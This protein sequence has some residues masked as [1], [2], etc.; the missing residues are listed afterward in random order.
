I[1]EYNLTPYIKYKGHCDL[2]K[3]LSDD[4]I[5]YVLSL[6]EADLILPESF[7]LA[8]A[9]GFSG[10]GISLIRKWPGCEYIFPN[11]MIKESIN[12]IVNSIVNLNKE[13]EKSFK[14][15]SM[16]GQDFIKLKYSEDKFLKIVLRDIFSL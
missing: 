1:E 15:I 16:K 5:G 10:G 2:K 3:S 7:H 12:D 9:D 11:F 14:I 4:K 6:S 8:V 13:G